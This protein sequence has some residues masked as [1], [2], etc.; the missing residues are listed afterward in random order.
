[1]SDNTA[2][3]LPLANRYNYSP[4]SWRDLTVLGYPH[5]IKEEEILLESKILGVSDV[6]EAMW[7]HR[8][9]RAAKSIQDTINELE[10][11]KGIRYDPEVVDVALGLFRQGRISAEKVTLTNV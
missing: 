9:Y 2:H 8:P 1:M 3:R 6:M 11:F 4:A 5:G 7:S 10:N